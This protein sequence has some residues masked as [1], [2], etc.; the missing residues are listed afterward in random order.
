[1]LNPRSPYIIIYSV[2]VMESQL[3]LDSIIQS[4]WEEHESR[5][6]VELADCSELKEPAI[7]IAGR[8]YEAYNN[9]AHIE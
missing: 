4:G 3:S 1:M 8:G 6:L 5:A 9:V 2:P 7:L